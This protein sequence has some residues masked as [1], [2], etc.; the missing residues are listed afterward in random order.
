MDS[1]N[2]LLL[3]ALQSIFA[4][5]HDWSAI[6]GRTTC[7]LEPTSNS[8]NSTNIEACSTHAHRQ[9]HA[10]LKIKPISAAVPAA[11]RPCATYARAR[12]H[13]RT[14]KRARALRRGC[15]FVGS[16]GAG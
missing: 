6:S 7:N 8:A 11:C 14:F 15:M 3:D 9:A 1:G 12:T 10:A 5:Y 2:A 4:R 13:T 16:R